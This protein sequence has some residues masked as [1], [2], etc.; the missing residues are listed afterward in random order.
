MIGHPLR[1][2]T[3][4]S[5]PNGPR[6]RTGASIMN[7][8]HDL[9]TLLPLALGMATLVGCD[10][11]PMG[12][13]FGERELDALAEDELDELDELDE[14]LDDDPVDDAG[15][16][17][18]ALDDDGTASAAIN[19]ALGKPATQSATLYGADAARA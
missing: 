14:A 18:I 16:D 4:P 8:R 13:G 17:D 2:T 10:P 7:T 1:P 15:P 5:T 19:L 11:E 9:R 6:A 12:E 3:P